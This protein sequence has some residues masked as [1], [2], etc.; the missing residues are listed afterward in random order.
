MNN[1]DD[2]KGVIFVAKII[3]LTFNDTEEKEGKLIVYSFPSLL[4]LLPVFL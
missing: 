1:A 3:I 4:F 2:Y